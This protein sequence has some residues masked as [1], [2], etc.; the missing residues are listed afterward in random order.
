M[1]D[2]LTA[3]QDFFSSIIELITGFFENIFGGFL[4]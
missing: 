4:G 1:A 2:I 3:I